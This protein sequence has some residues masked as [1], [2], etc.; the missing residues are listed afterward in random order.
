MATLQRNVDALSNTEY[1]L[2]IVGG[3]I[4]GASAT[5]EA[6][7]RGLKVALLEKTDF[8]HATS[9]NHFKM[10]HGGIRYLQHGDLVRIRESAHERS[11]LLRIAPHLVKPLPIVIPT[12]GHGIKGK[13]VLWTAMRL[14]DALTWDR[15]RDLLPDNRIPASRFLSRSQVLTMFPGIKSDNLTGG[16]LFHDGQMVSPTRLAISFLRSA[17]AAGATV[18]NYMEVTDFQR[19][20]DSIQAVVAKDCLTSKPITIRCKMVL[21]TAGPW[22]NRLLESALD[23]KLKSRPTFSRDLAFVVPKRF[24]GPCALAFATDSKDQDTLL[25]RGGRHLFAVPWKDFTLIG[26]WHKVFK[27]F[28][29]HITVSK[30]EM[31]AFLGEVNAGCPVLDLSLDQVQ[32]INTGLTL[33]GEEGQ[34]A[35]GAMSFGKRSMLI[36]HSHEQGLQGILTLIGVRAT[37]ARGMS[38]KAIDLVLKRLNRP[39]IPSKSTDVPIYGGDIPAMQAHMQEL[40]QQISGLIS[41]HRFQ[42]MLHH[43]GTGIFH[44]LRYGTERKELFSAIDN[45][46]LIKAEIVH[47]IREEAAVTLSDV[48]FRRTDFATGHLPAMDALGQCAQTMADEL[49]W[50]QVRVQEEM[51]NVIQ[52]F[53]N[54]SHKFRNGAPK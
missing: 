50:D 18:A 10:V 9:A 39:S 14:F 17:V 3:G 2:V 34:Q 51:N 1:D 41:P 32:L 4:F 40:Q 16:A 27:D 35:Q 37:T 11:A 23:V 52:Q 48:V 8:S 24:K 5:W 26:V 54:L 20:G 47:A 38:E 22:A 49:G 46:N 7:H 21:N 19:S 25:D 12:Y 29:D 44:V 45:C 6:A 42:L 13:E 28:P 15:N 30:A 31:E 43:Y 36:D 53:P 33:F